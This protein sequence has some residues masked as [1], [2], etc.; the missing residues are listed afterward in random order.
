MCYIYSFYLKLKI[1]NDNFSCK[2]FHLYN[3]ITSCWRQNKTWNNIYYVQN[4]S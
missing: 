3:V 4:S 1:K 2:L